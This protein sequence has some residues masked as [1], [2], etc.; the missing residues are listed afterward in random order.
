MH[1]LMHA[2]GGGVFIGTRWK[3]RPHEKSTGLKTCH[4]RSRAKVRALQGKAR[5]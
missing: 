3:P 5:V 4:Y 2:D 1:A